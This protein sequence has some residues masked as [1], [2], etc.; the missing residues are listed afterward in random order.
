[1]ITCSLWTVVEPTQDTLVK[2]PTG[3]WLT[4]LPADTVLWALVRL[5]KIRGRAECD[6]RGFKMVWGWT[7]RGTHLARLASSHHD[8]QRTQALLDVRTD[9]DHGALVGTGLRPRWSHWVRGGQDARQVAGVDGPSDQNSVR[10]RILLLFS[11]LGP[12]VDGRQSVIRDL[13]C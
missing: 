1:M 4:S 8:G 13:G 3:C 10:E 2:E 6:Y 9:R 11:Q 12:Y 5:A 7:T